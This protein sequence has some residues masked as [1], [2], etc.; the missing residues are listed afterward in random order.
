MQQIKISISLIEYILSVAPFTYKQIARRFSDLQVPPIRSGKY[1][2][3]TIYRLRRDFLHLANDSIAESYL[4][5]NGLK[6]AFLES[7]EKVGLTPSEKEIKLFLIGEG[8][9][10]WT[11]L[12][13]SDRLNLIELF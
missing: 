9:I 13:K 8:Y 4:N 11:T 12:H 5:R 3:T 2:P 1:H 6:D 7:C 10:K